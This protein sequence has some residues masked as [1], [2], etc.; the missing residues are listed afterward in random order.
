[1][2]NLVIPRGYGY[3]VGVFGATG[4]M[5]IYLMYNVI[6]AR[7]K[8]KVDYPHLY[9]PE[10]NEHKKEFDSVQRAHQNTLESYPIVMLQMLVSGLAYPVASAVFGGLWTIGRVIYGYGYG[11]SGPTGRMV[12][13]IVSHLGDFPLMGLIFKIAYDLI[14][15]E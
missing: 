15:A 10:S 9:A 1:M 12:G 7:K 6:Q 4:F 5:N 13:A 11:K 14:K 3:C 8:Y 2:S